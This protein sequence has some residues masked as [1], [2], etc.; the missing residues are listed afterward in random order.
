[1]EVK[2]GVRLEGH[3]AFQHG[4]VPAGKKRQQLRL[5]L[6]KKAVFQIVQ[7]LQKKEGALVEGGQGGDGFAAF[8]V[9]EPVTKLVIQIVYAQLHVRPDVLF[10]IGRNQRAQ[11]PEK[12]P[13]AV[14]QMTDFQRIPVT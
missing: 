14:E 11:P 5:R 12:I 10:R 7:V 3:G 1:M 4:M 2:G 9:N 13:G 6:R 8:P